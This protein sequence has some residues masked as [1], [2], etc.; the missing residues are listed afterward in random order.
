MLDFVLKVD[1][2]HEEIGFL[3]YFDSAGF[4]GLCVLTSEYISISAFSDFVEKSEVVEF[5]C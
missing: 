3:H 2:F 1:F 4:L 5:Q